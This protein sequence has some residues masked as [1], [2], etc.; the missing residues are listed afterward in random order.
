MFAVI[1]LETTG[2]SFRYEKIIEVAIVIFD[3]EKITKE[4]Q[5]LVN[6][7]RSIPPFITR[8]TGISNE[9]VADS[10]KFFEVAKQIVKLTE[11]QIFVAHNVNFDYNFLRQEY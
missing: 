7:E 3:G 11:D 6:P 9:M 2:G 1:D 4:Y 10:P 5:T 8:L